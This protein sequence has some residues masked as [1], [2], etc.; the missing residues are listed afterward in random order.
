MKRTQMRW[1]SL[2]VIVALMAG[3]FAPIANAQDVPTVHGIDRNDMNLDVEPGADF[4]DFSN[5]GWLAETELP[6]TNP[7]YG[8]FDELDDQVTELLL[9]ILAD[10]KPEEGTDSG[11]VASLFSQ[12]TDIETRAAQGVEPLQ[13]SLDNIAAIKT[14]DDALAYQSQAILDGFPGL[15]SVYAGPGLVDASVNIAWLGG[16]TLSLP[17]RPYYL[18]P[19]EDSQAIRD[20]WVETTAE[21]LGYLGYS[22][23]DAKAA[24]E[25]TL[26]FETE[27]AEA[28]TPD[29][30]RSD[31]ETYNSP[32]TIAELT[33]ILPGMDWE[34]YLASLGLTDTDTL[35]VDD[36]RYLNALGGILEGKDPQVLKDLFTVQLIWA[37]SPYLSEEIGDVA[38]SFNG[39]VL[40]GVDERRPIEERALYSVEATFPDALGQLYVAE[41]F[42]PEAKTAIEELVGN[43]IDA[44]RIRI[45]HSSW[46]SDATKLKAIEKLEKMRVKVGYPDTWETYEDVAIGDSYAETLNNASIAAIKD[47]LKDVGQPVDKDAWGMA[48]FEINAYYN[49]LGNEIVFPAAILQAPFFDPEAD[50]ASNY[51]GIGYVIGHEITHGFDLSGSQFDGDGNYVSWWTDADLEAFQALND[52]VIAQYSAIEAAPGL[53]VNGELSIGENVA[54]MGGLQTAFDAMHADLA[55]L[56]DEELAALPWFLTPDQ[57]FF[58]SAATVWRAKATEEFTQLIVASDEHAPSFIRAVQPARNMDGFYAAFGINESDAEYLAPDERIVIW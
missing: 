16:P 53:M 13:P 8:V 31:I 27:V 44:F 35:Y 1:A 54:D 50:P 18:D 24:A 34:A 2:L 48:V 40:N 11:R 43:L 3:I 37:A 32:R 21:L 51:G 45:E 10:L 49:P 39:P 46:M 56:S 25:S 26:A 33:E 22:D 30:E 19:S 12:A 23:V 14:I 5:G 57:R 47:N 58:V 55:G 38:F 42:S 9:D 15:F 52:E 41:A 28:M 17:S 4:Y 6:A 20:A 36:I 29:E 7:S